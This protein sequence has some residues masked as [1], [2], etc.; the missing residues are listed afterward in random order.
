MITINIKNVEELILSNNRVKRLIPEFKPL[1]RRWA[2][3][4]RFSGF[5]YLSQKAVLELLE[6][7]E[8][9][10]ITILE[11]HFAENI[12]IEKTDYRIAKNMQSSTE[13][14]EDDLC[15]LEGFVDNFS[16]TRDDSQVY[17]SFWR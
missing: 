8:H 2:M 11:N 13:C 12:K 1:F 15:N 10:H 9:E 17:I 16:I 6:A 4:K 3:G 7:L 14:L 5:S